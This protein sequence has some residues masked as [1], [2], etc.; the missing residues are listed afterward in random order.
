MICDFLNKQSIDKVPIFTNH[1]TSYQSIET[2]EDGT[3]VNEIT[4]QVFIN[5]IRL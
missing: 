1:V 4:F 3:Y 2:K 5:D